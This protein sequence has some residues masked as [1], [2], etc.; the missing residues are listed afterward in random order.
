MYAPT[1]CKYQQNVTNLYQKFYLL[2][3]G[4]NDR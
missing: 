2:F 1:P 3:I 4:E